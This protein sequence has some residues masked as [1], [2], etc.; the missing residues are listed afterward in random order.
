[1]GLKRSNLYRAIFF[2]PQVISLLANGY[3]WSYI[4][5]KDGPLNK[6]LEFIGLGMLE[7]SWFGNF[8][9]ALGS[10][11]GMSI[12]IGAGYCMVIFLAN[13]QSI[14][15]EIYEAADIDGAKGWKKFYYVTLPLLVPSITINLVL[16][17]IYG[18]K[19]FDVVMST[20]GGGPGYA[21]ETI[22]TLMYVTA[23]V[24]Q[25]FGEATAMGIVMFAAIL[26]V[27]LVQIVLLRR[28]EVDM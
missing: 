10:L 3:I 27:S 15:K 20:T 13:L 4:L 25:S 19:A 21:T 1:M 26:T 9:L 7:Q 5:T 12:W 16:G 6:F 18:L 8:R 14:P 11:V 23:F 24:N 28:K 2:T 17:M 22:S